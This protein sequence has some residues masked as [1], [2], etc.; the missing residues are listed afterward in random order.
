MNYLS[1]KDYWSYNQGEMDYKEIEK[2]LT[3]K[4]E[5]IKKIHKDDEDEVLH[6]FLRDNLSI[7]H[8]SKNDYL[9]YSKGFILSTKKIPVVVVGDLHSDDLTLDRIIEKVDPY[10]KDVFMVFLGDYVDRG[11]GHLAIL[12]KLW[13]LKL[14]LP[15]QILLLRGNHDSGYMD[16]EGVR[17][18]YGKDLG[19]EE[20]DFFPLY[21]DDLREKGLISEDFMRTYFDFCKTLPHIAMIKLENQ[22]TMCV[23]G[24]LPRP[25]EKKPYYD[26][27][28]TLSSLADD[29]LVDKIG[30]SIITNMLW[31]DPTEG[32]TGIIGESGRFKTYESHF[33][34]FSQ[35]FGIDRLIRGHVAVKEGHKVIYNGR[36]H[37]I[38]SSGG[39]SEHTAYN[40]V[41]VPKVIRIEENGELKIEEI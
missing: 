13:S 8:F 2:R 41:K 7:K 18:E 21:L 4:I 39:S 31:S 32:E 37:T 1:A 20:R 22:W 15:D 40:K 9:G 27:I 34:E 24:G 6:E 25:N 17:L 19:S 16:A 28:E 12:D 5:G 30:R 10:N 35:R 33:D 23:H 26:Y 3:A 29:Q 38:F 14:D 36:L 11:K